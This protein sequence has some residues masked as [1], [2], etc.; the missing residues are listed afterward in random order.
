MKE[1]YAH[2]D[3]GAFIPK[4]QKSHYY[5]C[6]EAPL[7]N[8]QYQ[9]YDQVN[10]AGAPGGTPGGPSGGPPAAG[11]GIGPPPSAKEAMKLLGK[12]PKLTDRDEAAEAPEAP[13]PVVINQSTTQDLSLPEDDFSYQKANR[14][15][16]AGRKAK[17]V[18]KRIVA[19]I[20]SAT[21][22]FT[23]IGLF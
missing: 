4:E 15:S 11:P 17:Q 14:P 13:S 23:G 1:H 21:R 9:P 3:P 2:Y 12:E 18:G 7:P 8:K 5:K 19:P 22:R 6:R 20:N 16:W 10:T